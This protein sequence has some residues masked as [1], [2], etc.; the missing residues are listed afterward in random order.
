MMMHIGAKIPRTQGNETHQK[1]LRR[2]ESRE[3]LCQKEERK[4]ESEMGKLGMEDGEDPT[5]RL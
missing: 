3:G 5:A 2:R 4:K 1:N